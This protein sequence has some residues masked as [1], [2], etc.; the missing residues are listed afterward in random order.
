MTAHNEHA[1]IAALT[2]AAL[3]N[4][5]TIALMAIQFV[6]PP[7]FVMLICLVPAIFAL[8]ALW[9]PPSVSLLSGMLAVATALAF[10]GP[11]VAAWC[12]IYVLAGLVAGFARRLRFPVA[13]RIAVVMVSMMALVSGVVAL[14][15]WLAGIPLIPLLTQ[16]IVPAVVPLA[17]GISLA[18]PNLG[19][20][21][22]L[23]LIVLALIAAAIVDGF[24]GAM[25][26]RVTYTDTEPRQ[27]GP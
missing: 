3:L 1:R 11:A 12:G 2:L 8:E 10:F 14:F 27:A 16:P 21:A 17:P 18:L 5:I 7:A 4:G 13:L 24:I 22:L 6:V 15:V 26:A 9:T 25:L 19:V 20:F 23:G